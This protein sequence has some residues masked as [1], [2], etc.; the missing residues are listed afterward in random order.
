[1]FGNLQAEMARRGL[2]GRAVAKFI[3]VQEL[4]MYN[5]L[6]GTTE[7]KLS[8]MEAIKNLLESDDSMDYLF[9]R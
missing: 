6:N 1:M 9:K 8:E 4:T 5:K 3:G 2:T 7:F